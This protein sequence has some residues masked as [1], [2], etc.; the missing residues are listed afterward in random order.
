MLVFNSK[1]AEVHP[2]LQFG[3]GKETDFIE[4]RHPL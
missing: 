3:G 2:V 4:G 1:R